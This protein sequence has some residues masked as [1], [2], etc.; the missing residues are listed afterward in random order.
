MKQN[1]K[2]KSRTTSRVS[3]RS[4]RA[5]N[6][7]PKPAKGKKGAT[8]GKGAPLFHNNTLKHG[9]NS[10]KRIAQDV[11]I[12]GSRSRALSRL[13]DKKQP[14]AQA[15]HQWR[16]QL[17]QSYGGWKQMN[18]LLHEILAMAT[19]MKVVVDSIGDF[20]AKTNLIDRKR[21]RLYPVVL[22]LDRLMNS[23]V[24]RLERF[25]LLM[26]RARAPMHTVEDIRR[27]LGE[28]EDETN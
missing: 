23:Q 20:A 10:I 3:R 24:N 9:Y 16:D 27:S 12:H 6:G 28:G 21:R 14:W 5:G 1:R 4:P 13:L 2:P 25:A 15:L 11:R 8:R 18:P 17:V 26:D 19:V 22:D 7:T